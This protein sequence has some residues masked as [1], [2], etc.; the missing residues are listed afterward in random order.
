MC[1]TLTN[2]QENNFCKHQ[3]CIGPFKDHTNGI[4]GK[5]LSQGSS[6]LLGTLHPGNVAMN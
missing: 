6:M 4:I 1:I 5:V 2:C 3:L